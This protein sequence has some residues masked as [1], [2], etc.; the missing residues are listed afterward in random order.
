MYNF[1]VFKFLKFQCKIQSNFENTVFQK[2]PPF[3]FE[4]LFQKLF[5]ILKSDQN[6]SCKTFQS[7]QL[8][9]WKIFKL[10]SKIKSNFAI[11][12]LPQFK[13]VLPPI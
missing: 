8:L 9:F 5:G 11:S 13:S 3:E 4:S 7:E 6:K 10:L 1:S 2:M 12:I